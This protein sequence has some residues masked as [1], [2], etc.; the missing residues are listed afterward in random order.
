[1]S[2][3]K[4]NEEQHGITA[5]DDTPFVI[6]GYGETIKREGAK[7]REVHNVSPQSYHLVFLC[8]CVNEPL[9]IGSSFCCFIRP[10]CSLLLRRQKSRGGAKHLCT[11]TVSPNI[12]PT[13]DIGLYQW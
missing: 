5:A 8:F 12:L 1:M 6:A 11:Y 7:T 4:G 2:E 10:R 3:G 13:L 9:L